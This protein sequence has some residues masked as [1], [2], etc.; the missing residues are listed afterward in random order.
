MRNSSHSFN[1]EKILDRSL[2]HSSEA[3][4]RNIFRRQTD[5]WLPT[6]LTS[7]ASI[8]IDADGYLV[9]SVTPNRRN[10]DR[11]LRRPPEPYAVRND[12]F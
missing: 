7:A 11:Q 9:K 1:G 6:S 8:P 4:S 2:F 12:T 10:L 5:L 3:H